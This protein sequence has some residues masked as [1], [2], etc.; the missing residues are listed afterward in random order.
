MLR[1]L[2]DHLDRDLKTDSFTLTDDKTTEKTT[3]RSSKIAK[4]FSSLLK[5]HPFTTATIQ[6]KFKLHTFERIFGRTHPQKKVNL[7]IVFFI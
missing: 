2:Q 5:N 4:I 3:S 7:C 6:D 1:V